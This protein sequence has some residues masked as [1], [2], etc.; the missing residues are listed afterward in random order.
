MRIRNKK[1]A[2][3]AS[4]AWVKDYANFTDA[5]YMGLYWGL[6]QKDIHTKKKL[7]P[8]DAILDYMDSEELAA[9][10]FRTTQAE[11]KIRREEIKGQD[12]VSIA[13]YEIGKKVRK[14]IKEI[15]WTMPENLPSVE[16]IKIIEKKLKWKTRI[17]L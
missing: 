13:H 3:T 11:S 10:L 6:K 4:K 15:D 2:S 9:N 5:G 8:K 7:K 16:N 17:L 12:N 1:L 14:T